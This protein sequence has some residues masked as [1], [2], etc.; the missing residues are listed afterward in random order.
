MDGDNQNW[1]SV[2]KFGQS[3]SSVSERAFSYSLLNLP[4]ELFA[5]VLCSRVKC[6][7]DNTDSVYKTVMCSTL[8]KIRRCTKQYSAQ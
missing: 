7:V 6:F 3:G 5:L 4:G 2:T 1:N 8:N